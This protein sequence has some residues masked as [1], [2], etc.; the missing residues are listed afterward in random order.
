MYKELE[1]YKTNK[2]VDSIGTVIN[3]D[4][5]REVPIKLDEYDAPL[6][7]LIKDFIRHETLPWWKK[8]Y[9]H[10]HL[11]KLYLQFFNNIN[12]TVYM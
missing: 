12:V 6:G 4:P 9:Y 7:D 3:V 2:K 8:K 11:T 10:N 1:K 5:Q